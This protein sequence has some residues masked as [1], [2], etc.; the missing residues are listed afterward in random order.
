MGE[1][2]EDLDATSDTTS[3][4]KETGDI[5]MVRRKAH[6]HQQSLTALRFRAGRDEMS[7]CVKSIICP[8]P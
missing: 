6:Y 4:Y 3:L 7:A 5:S 2:A 8:P 1:Q